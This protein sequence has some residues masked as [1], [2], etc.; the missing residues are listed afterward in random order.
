MT[1][2]RARRSA[3]RLWIELWRSLS[4]GE[5]TRLR[6]AVG[7]ILVGSI[8]TALTPMLVGVFVDSV[9]RD[10]QLVGLGDAWMPITLLAVAGLVIGATGLIRHQQIHIVTTSFTAN[11]RQ[12]IYAALLRW[13]LHRF[14]DDAKGALYGRANRS[15]EGAERLIKLGAADLLP[16]VLV[17]AFAVVIAVAQFGWL[18]LCM[19]A[20]IP[21]G[22]ALV[23][24][25][26]RSQNGIRVKVAEAKQRIDADVTALLGGVDVIRT[27][28]AESYFDNRVVARTN[29]LRNEERKHHNAMAIFDL[30]KIINE[31]VWLVVVLVAALL[32]SLASPGDLASMVLLYLAITRPMRELHRVIDE[33]AEAALQTHHL[34]DDLAAPYDESYIA[35]ATSQRSSETDQPALELRNVTFQYADARSPILNGVNLVV[36]QGERIGIVG[37]SGCGKSTLL[38]LTARLMHGYNGS[39]LLEGSDV[40]TLDRAELTRTVGYVSQRSTLFQ[41]T[42]RENLTLGRE[43]LTDADLALACARANIHDEILAMPNGYETVIGEEGARLSGGQSQRL[44]L[45][46]ALVSTPPVMLL[47]EP[48]SALDG[49]SQ[50][51]VQRAIDELE[52]VTIVIVAHRLS[53]LRTTDRI[54]VMH[55]GQ[56]IEEGTYDS[57]AMADGAF[58]RMLESERRAA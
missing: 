18:G 9:Y 57:L 25:Q 4:A 33:G 8:A 24:W 6:V 19:V 2:K 29:A 12:R 1:R 46:R 55:D 37:A 5:R 13:P 49:P 27:N 48:T 32:Q 45:A 31:T 51:V 30:I 7:A 10:G 58:S 21:T 56:I 17:T 41:G 34:Q 22:F 11:M 28:G 54:L 42:I 36:S 20:V 50:A 40:Q 26:I 39:I 53:T 23:I 47:D 52:D 38:K 44:C 3:V 16:A 15:I 43:N 35:T 14:V